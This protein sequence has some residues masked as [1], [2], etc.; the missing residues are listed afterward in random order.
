M[1]LG[2]A[3]GS[4]ACVFKGA[5]LMVRAESSGGVQAALSWWEECSA[6]TGDWTH[7]NNHGRSGATENTEKD[8]SKSHMCSPEHGEQVKLCQTV[9]VCLVWTVCAV[10]QRQRPV[11]G[12]CAPSR[13]RWVFSAQQLSSRKNKHV[14]LYKAA[15]REAP[16]VIPACCLLFAAWLTATGS[17]C[18]LDVLS[19]PDGDDDATWDRWSLNHNHLWKDHKTKLL[20]HY[21]SD[22]GHKSVV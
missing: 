5:C 14:G 4:A 8:I 19:G 17:V 12:C 3:N 22:A 6:Q 1:T 20:R 11:R 15:H 7:G 21:D 10:F 13:R 9:H 16:Q 18:V 2:P